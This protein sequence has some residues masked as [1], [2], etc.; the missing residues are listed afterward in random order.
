MGNTLF[1][2]L[3]NGIEY[4]YCLLLTNAESRLIYILYI[5]RLVLIP[6]Y[7]RGDGVKLALY[8]LIRCSI[9]LSSL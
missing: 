9:F 3:I 1:L 7:Y 4:L 2:I 5:L 8:V 6:L